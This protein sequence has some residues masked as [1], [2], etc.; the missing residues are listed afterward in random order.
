MFGKRV[1][2]EKSGDWERPLA[3]LGP[4]RWY[5]VVCA[6]RGAGPW[7][8]AADWCHGFAAICRT[9]VRENQ[10]HQQCDLNLMRNGIGSQCSSRNAGVRHSHVVEGPSPT[11]QLHSAFVAIG[12]WLTTVD[13][14]RWNCSSQDDSGWTPT[15]AAASH[16]SRLC[17][18]FLC[19]LKLTS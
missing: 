12:W 16:C 6:I 5:D 8:A 18:H 10:E 19:V 3:E 13:R 17:L 14:S 7:W 11:G 4:C 15:R 9:L 1:P 2:N